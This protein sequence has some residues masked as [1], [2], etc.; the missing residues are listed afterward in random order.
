MNFSIYKPTD[1]FYETMIDFSDYESSPLDF[2][3]IQFVEDILTEYNVEY[4]RN[5]SIS[6]IN[7]SNSVCFHIEGEISPTLEALLKMA[8]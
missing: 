2:G 6:A 4:I 3:I 8:L 5:D 7:D 1:T